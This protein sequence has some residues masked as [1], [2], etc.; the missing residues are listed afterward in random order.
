MDKAKNFIKSNLAIFSYLYQ[1]LLC[2]IFH[3]LEVKVKGKPK[4]EGK[5]YKQGQE[6]MPSE[7]FQIEEFDDGTSI[8]TITETYPDDTGEIVFEVHNPLGVST[9]MTYL[10]VEGNDSFIPNEEAIF[11][12]CRSFAN[13]LDT[14]SFQLRSSSI[15]FI[16]E[17]L[18]MLSLYLPHKYYVSKLTLNT[19]ILSLLYTFFIFFH[20]AFCQLLGPFEF[21]PLALEFLCENDHKIPNLVLTRRLI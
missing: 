12:N 1:F 7:E 16:S 10:S 2:S 19:H 11:E 17:N 15:G 18:P 9:T 8:L 4:P 14:S 13:L 6:I 3:R 20:L 21:H 5:W